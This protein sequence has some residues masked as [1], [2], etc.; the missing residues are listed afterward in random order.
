MGRLITLFKAIVLI[1]ALSFSQ[2]FP[3]RVAV[4]DDNGGS[5]Q[6]PANVEM[7]LADTLQFTTTR[8]NA[9]DIRDGS[10]NKFDVVV[11]PGGSG[12]KQA[13]NLEPSGVDSIRQFVQRG[14]GYLGICAG[15]YL[16]T[17]EYDWSL[18]ILNAKVID[19]AHWNRGK[20]DV[21]IRL[22]EQGKKF[23]DLTSDTLTL[24][25]AQ[26][27]LMAAAGVDSLPP[28]VELAT[29]VTEIAKNN[30]PFGIMFGK[31]AIAQVEYGNGRVF[32]L[33]PHPEKSEHLR[34]MVARSVQWLAKRY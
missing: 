13:K 27:P 15:A 10:L 18:H 25:Y 17:A 23:F 14:G 32:A 8:V 28:Y 30:A 21:V 9:K 3:I 22:T 6:G 19:R 4:Y 1:S 26:G 5:D 16:A 11:Q 34:G 2:S 24:N 29:F 31:T 12:S 20:G 7:S 33:S